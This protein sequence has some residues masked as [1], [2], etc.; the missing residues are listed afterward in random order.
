MELC[1][2]R[3]VCSPSAIPRDLQ[4][5]SVWLRVAQ[6][7][8]PALE[9]KCVRASIQSRPAGL[10]VSEEGSGRKSQKCSRGQFLEGLACQVKVFDLRPLWCREKA[11]GDRE[12]ALRSR[13]R[14]LPLPPSDR[15]AA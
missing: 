9:A 2:E 12:E 1:A 15:S 13:A 7:V 4:K 14:I 3:V 8:E 10:T 6:L 11:T 5:L